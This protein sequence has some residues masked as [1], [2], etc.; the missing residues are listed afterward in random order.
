[1]LLASDNWH[2]LEIGVISFTIYLIIIWWPQLGRSESN[3]KC[4][5]DIRNY[6]I[7]CHSLSNMYMRTHSGNGYQLSVTNSSWIVSTGYNLI[8]ISR[9]TRKGK[10]ALKINNSHKQHQRLILQIISFLLRPN[11]KN[12]II[13]WMVHR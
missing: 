5:N 11:K 8:P 3:A 7:E 10:S 4:P 6:Q 9:K 12:N 13:E 1:M 2:W